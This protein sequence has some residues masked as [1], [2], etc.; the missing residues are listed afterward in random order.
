MRQDRPPNNDKILVHRSQS[1]RYLTR[2]RMETCHITCKLKTHQTNGDDCIPENAHVLLSLHLSNPA[3]TKDTQTRRRLG[4]SDY[5]PRSS[6]SALFSLFTL[7]IPAGLCTHDYLYV[8]GDRRGTKM[9][10]RSILAVICLDPRVCRWQYWRSAR[11]LVT[12]L[13][14]LQALMNIMVT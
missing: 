9:K 13:P 8:T 14:Q 7:R 2:L 3:T 10:G 4:V 1:Y 12:L 11:E 6:E 5:Q